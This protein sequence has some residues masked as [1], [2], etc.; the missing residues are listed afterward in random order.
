[1]LEMQGT[2]LHGIIC[3]DASCWSRGLRVGSPPLLGILVLGNDMGVTDTHS[4]SLFPLL[5]D[6]QHWEVIG[7]LHRAPV[8]LPDNRDQDDCLTD[9]A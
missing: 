6:G 8:D 9:Y 1:M 4:P 7:A 3:S 2:L 5:Q